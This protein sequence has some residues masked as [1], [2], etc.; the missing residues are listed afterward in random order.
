M[1]SA[2]GL[3]RSRLAGFILENVDPILTDWENFARQIWPASETSLRNL[4]DDAEEILRAIAVD[5]DTEQTSARQVEKSKGA[6]DGSESSMRVN[7]ASD[8]HVLGRINSGFDL[9]LVVAEYRALRASVIRLWE[10]CHHMEPYAGQV[11]EMIRFNESMDQ[12]L[13]EAVRCY[14]E[15][16]EQSRDIFLG[17]LGHDLRNP[18]VAITML[19]EL[20]MQPDGRADVAGVAAKISASAAAMRQMI[21]DI[22]DFT[23]NRLGG[24]MTIFPVRMDLGNLGREVLE[25]MKAAHPTR[26]FRFECHGDLHGKWDGARLRQVLTNLLGNAVQHGSAATPVGLSIIGDGE[27]VR[28]EVRNQGP[29]IPENAR[30]LI[31]EPLIRKPSAESAGPSGSIGLGLFIVREIA[32][33]HGGVADV[34]SSCAETVFTVRLPRGS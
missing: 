10:E 20:L 33:R 1:V 7:R 30:E 5:M 29:P 24:Q 4:R 26:A 6:G 8:L 2:T 11:G 13:T 25:E 32:A 15:R 22:L 28:I 18:L 23:R 3:S 31:F 9:L 21:A 19:S 27:E 16:V 12:L 34:E 17:M 14:T